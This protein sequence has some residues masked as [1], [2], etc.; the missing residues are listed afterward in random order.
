[1]L[2][3]K[4]WWSRG[5]IDECVVCPNEFI[6]KVV[7]PWVFCSSPP[8]GFFPETSPRAF[9]KTSSSLSAS[10]T[11]WQGMYTYTVCG[12]SRHHMAS[13]DSQSHVAAKTRRTCKAYAV[14]SVAFPFLLVAILGSEWQ[15][16]LTSCV[17]VGNR[18]SAVYG[19]DVSHVLCL[20]KLDSNVTVAYLVG[21]KNVFVC[22][23]VERFPNW[24]W[25]RCRCCLFQM[26]SRTGYYQSWPCSGSWPPPRCLP[27]VHL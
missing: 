22:F 24:G 12:L 16:R 5:G 9:P 23:A 7:P 25:K 19:R 14:M 2:K 17:S 15:W 26:K 13:D 4:S 11:R 1:M 18:W 21:K 10:W 27:S 8:V 3:A 6:S 20:G